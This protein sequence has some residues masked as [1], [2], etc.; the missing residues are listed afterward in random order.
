MKRLFYLLPLMLAVFTSCAQTNARSS[1][2]LNCEGCE[3]IFES[4]VP[5]EQ[6]N[7]VDTLPDFN[8]A[9]AKM[10]VTG[11]IY[12]ADGKTPANNVV[13]Y[14][15]HT[16][17][18]GIYAKKGDE[19][20]W[21][22]RH[23]YIRGWIRTGADGRYSFYTLR[24]A[25]YPREKIPAHIHPVLKESDMQPYYVDEFL[26][27]DDPLLSAEERRKQPLYGGSGILKPVKENGMLVARRDI[28]LGLN[29]PGY[30]TKKGL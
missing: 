20:G 8:D 6:L 10:L 16:D 1:F 15:Y 26:F 7:A 5:W 19:K 4:T 11:I 22:K 2:K 12:E 23:G 28:V 29:I 27:D 3:A 18:Y 21:A 24:P 9:G 14:I 30:P 25:A 17:Q 13:L